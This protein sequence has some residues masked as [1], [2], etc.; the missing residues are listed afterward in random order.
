MKRLAVIMSVY[1][2]DKYNFLKMAVESVLN[3][4]Y[5]NFDFFIQGDGLLNNDCLKY[6]QSLN[7]NRVIF[8]ESLE[9]HGLAKSLNNLLV[10]S[11]LPKKYEYIARMDA[12][13]VCVLNR[14]EIQIE[15]LDKNHHIDIVG[16]YINEINED[17]VFLQKVVYPVSHDEM[18]IFFGKRNPLAHMTVIFRQSF[19]YKS[20]LYPENTKLDEDTMLW[21]EGFKN[22]CLFSNIPEVMVNVRVNSDFYSRRNGFKKSFADFKNRIKIIK[23]LN[24]SAVNYLWAFAR[25]LLIGMPFESLTKFIY[26]KMRD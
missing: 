20:G 21:F 10:Y 18:K 6:L 5:S 3:Q 22:S 9:N 24:L 23:E 16:G 13:D 12:D 11:I 15:F 25:F 14:F 1:K 26:R 19:F 4:S 8:K 7:D 2:N 17:N